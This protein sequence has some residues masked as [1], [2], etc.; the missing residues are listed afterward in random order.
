MDGL[1]WFE[2]KRTKG[3]KSVRWV[4]KPRW[5]GLRRGGVGE[6]AH[7]THE[8]EGRLRAG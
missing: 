7:E 5:A 4:G 2:Q 1:V 3:T 6:V 8:K